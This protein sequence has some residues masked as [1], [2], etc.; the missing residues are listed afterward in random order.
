MKLAI[1]RLIVV[2][3]LS[4]SWG[5]GDLISSETGS[6]SE[7]SDDTAECEETEDDSNQLSS[8]YTKEGRD[9]YNKHSTVV[10]ATVIIG[11]LLIA[12]FSWVGTVL[13]LR[14]DLN[15]DPNL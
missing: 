11:T 1:L 8:K 12:I 15:F 4:I 5:K 3:L 13:L 7:S 9:A 14:G 10:I 6:Y 2:C